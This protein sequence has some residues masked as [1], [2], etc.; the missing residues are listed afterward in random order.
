[1]IISC[2]EEN[3]PYIVI[4]NYYDEDEYNSIWEE[5]NFLCHRDKLIKSE[6][7]ATSPDGNLL[8]NNCVRY[9]DNLYTDR[10]V[11]NIL[12]VNRKLFKNHLEILRYHPSWFFQNIE[13]NNDFTSLSY[14]EDG[15]EYLSHHD[16]Y[17]V[18]ALWWT[19][20][21]PKRFEGGNFI[22]TDYNESVE[23]KDNRLVIFPSIIKHEVTKVKIEEEYRNQKNGRICLSQFL[24]FK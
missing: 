18:T 8:K 20:N 1:M 14:Y 11:S 7:S 10:K 17:T 6:G 21:K 19:H 15:E 13:G 2:Y 22:F 12:K 23:F 5:I 3:F 16:A 4:D 9:L 24:K